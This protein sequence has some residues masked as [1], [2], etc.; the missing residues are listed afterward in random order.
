MESHTPFVKHPTGKKKKKRIPVLH[1]KKNKKNP[2]AFLY[3]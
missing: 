3:P 2:E 1:K